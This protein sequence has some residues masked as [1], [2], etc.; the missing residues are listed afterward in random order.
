MYRQDF[1]IINYLNSC[2]KQNF[3]VISLKLLLQNRLIMYIIIYKSINI[4]ILHIINLI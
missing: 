4:K 1:K 3:T 2:C